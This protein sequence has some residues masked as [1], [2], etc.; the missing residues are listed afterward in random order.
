MDRTEAALES[1]EVQ[2][3]TF[4]GRTWVAD[5][6]RLF[7][8]MTA[9]ALC[10]IWSEEKIQIALIGIGVYLFY[11]SWTWIWTLKGLVNQTLIRIRKT[12]YYILLRTCNDHAIDCATGTD[13]SL[14][15]DIRNVLC[16][17]SLTWHHVRH[18]DPIPGKTLPS[19][20]ILPAPTQRFVA[21]P[22]RSLH[23]HTVQHYQPV[24]ILEICPKTETNYLH[25]PI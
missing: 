16:N 4:I 6:F 2:L 9:V 24:D 10:I 25:V 8:V 18:T 21:I 12:I 14:S 11:C 7:V 13:D 17:F 22:H 3:M 19:T 15:P 20:R 5:K 1:E 23:M